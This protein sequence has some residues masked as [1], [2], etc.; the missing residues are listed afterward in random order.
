MQRTQT[1]SPFQGVWGSRT[2]CEAST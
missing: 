2:C 1:K